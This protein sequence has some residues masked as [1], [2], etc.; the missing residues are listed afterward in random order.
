MSEPYRDER[1]RIRSEM[2]GTDKI[3]QLHAAGRR[4]A[5]EHLDLLLDA[6]SFTE[7]GMFARSERE[8]DQAS[9]PA[10]GKICGH[11]TIGQRPVTVAVDDVTVKRATS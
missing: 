1:A 8:A 5:R 2:G 3:A 9:T 10:D 4:T 11:G 6:G 7:V